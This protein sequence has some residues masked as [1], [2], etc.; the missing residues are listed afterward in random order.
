MRDLCCRVVLATIYQIQPCAHV[1]RVTN[2][3]TVIIIIIVI[4]IT[5]LFACLCIHPSVLY[6]LHLAALFCAPFLC[7]SRMLQSRSLLCATGNP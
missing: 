2:F 5:A 1:V 4:I 3:H 6:H 7:A